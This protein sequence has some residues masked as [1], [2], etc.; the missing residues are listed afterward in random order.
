LDEQ[1]GGIWRDGIVI[2]GY[3]GVG[4]SVFA[5]H[6]AI[7][8]V[9]GGHEVIYLDL[10]NDR[11]DILEAFLLVFLS[12]MMGDKAPTRMQL[13]QNPEILRDTETILMFE[14]DV[15]DRAWILDA[16]YEKKITPAHLAELIEDRMNVLKAE[17][18]TVVLLIDSLNELN[19]LWPLGKGEYESMQRWLAEI[20]HIKAKYQIPVVLI[21]HVTKIPNREE[22]MTPKGTSGLGHFARTQLI[23]E[24]DE[25]QKATVI[26]K[27]VRSQF[28]EVGQT[29]LLFD[30]TRLSL[31]ER[32]V[33]VP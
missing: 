22:M 5:K 8:A 28:G 14:R 15:G 18:K 20:K 12:A 26:V 19:S 11:A 10:E 29:K 3:P 7:P 23:I 6:L 24:I 4:K 1:I 21:C 2:S 9:V 33:T 32:V 17:D 13:R 31:K 30:R 16:S 25:N 27:V